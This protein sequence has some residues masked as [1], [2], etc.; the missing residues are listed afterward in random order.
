MRLRVGYAPVLL[1]GLAALPAGAATLVINPTDSAGEGFYDTTPWTPTGGNPATTLGD[2]RLNVFKRAAVMWGRRINSSVTITVNASFDPLDC[3]ATSGTL[4]HAGSP[5]MYVA[6]SATPKVLY[7]RALRNAIRGG[8]VGDGEPDITAAF[9]SLVGTSSC[10]GGADFY[11]GYDHNLASG[12]YVADLLGVVLHELAHGLGFLSMVQSNGAGNT[13]NGNE[14]FSIFDQF[15]YDESQGKF[16]SAM[17]DAQRAVSVLNNGNL[18][19]NDD[20]RGGRIKAGVTSSYYPLP[21]TAGVTSGGHLRLYAPTTWV[22]GSSISHWDKTATP[23]LLLEPV[24]NVDTYNHTDLTTCVLY[25][26]GWGGTRCPDRANAV[27]LATSLTVAT[28]ADTAVAVTLSATDADGDALTYAI[29]TQPTYGALSGSGTSYTYTPSAGFSGTDSFTY[30]AYDGLDTSAPATVTITVQPAAD[31]SSSSSSGSGS[32]SSS[33]SSSGSGSGGS[34]G[35]DGSSSSSS[36]ADGS[37]SSSSSGSGSSSGSDASSSSGGSSSSGSSNGT[38]SSTGSGS[39]G[40]GA[41]GGAWLAVLGLMAAVR[42][43]RHHV[44]R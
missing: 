19:W 26:L 11:Y 10:L 41:L 17:T 37:S 7:P 18:V 33:G 4:G 35:S 27:P 20:S 6:L 39:G 16:W 40:G 15:I 9:N 13:A 31:S 25:D 32:S 24:Y 36:G 23:N 44:R 29:A 14:Y 34:S 2:A 8:D 43:R 21:L 30:T 5:Y 3:S 12:N 42:I 38:A 1:L 28:A 22:T